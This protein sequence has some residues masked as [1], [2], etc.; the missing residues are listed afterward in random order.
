MKASSSKEKILKKIREALSNPVP[1]PFPKSEGTNYVFQPQMDD[2]EILFAE[3]FTKLLG[4]FAFCVNEKD[5]NLQLQQLVAEKKW[6]NIY[7][8]EESLLKMID[9]GKSLNLN[10]STLADCDA[11]I[12]SCRFLVARTGA[13]VMTSAQQSGRTVSAYA[14]VHICI[15]WINQLVY[16]T[17]D[18]L[19]SLKAAGSDNIPSFITF[20]A[21]PSRTADIEKTLVVGV[22]GP[23]EVYL[24]LIDKSFNG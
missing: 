9:D 19:K 2:L 11:S 4:K 12:T 24:F 23:K 7:C 16:D 3:E 14:P 6:K 22:H 13:I 10:K 5:L 20:A 17:R 8:V 15:A 18:V 1:L 21:G